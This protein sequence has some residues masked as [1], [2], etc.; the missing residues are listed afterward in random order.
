MNKKYWQNI[1]HVN[2][3]VNSQV[4]NLT[5]VKTVITKSVDARVKIWKNIMCAKK[6]AFGIL[7]DV[8]AKMINI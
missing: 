4:E 3:N 7:L 5:G 2:V 6:V 8:V 1:H